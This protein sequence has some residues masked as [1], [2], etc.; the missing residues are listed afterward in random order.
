[1]TIA[2]TSLKGEQNKF[3]TNTIT[4]HILDFF[5]LE[6]E[7]RVHST[8]QKYATLSELV[9]YTPHHLPHRPLQF[10]TATW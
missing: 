1:M 9:L 7:I 5:S 8:T 4:V 2:E 3:A 6:T 10:F